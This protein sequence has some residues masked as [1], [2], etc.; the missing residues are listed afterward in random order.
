MTTANETIELQIIQPAPNNAPPSPPVGAGNYPNPGLLPPLPMVL[1]GSTTVVTTTT[2]TTTPAVVIATPAAPLSWQRKQVYD[3]VAGCEKCWLNACGCMLFVLG[4]FESFLRSIWH[5]LCILGIGLI[6]LFTCCLVKCLRKT[7]RKHAKLCSW[8]CCGLFCWTCCP[9]DW[10]KYYQ[11]YY[12]CS[13]WWLCC[14]CQ[15]LLAKHTCL[16]CCPG[17]RTVIEY[18]DNS[19]AFDDDDCCQNCCSGGCGDC[20]CDCNC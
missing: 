14:C 19:N 11:H 4:P 6:T 12:C 17:S 20:D 3:S 9:V 8:H 16:R 5:F 15:R 7:T 1:P 10:P 18:A 2:T 13:C